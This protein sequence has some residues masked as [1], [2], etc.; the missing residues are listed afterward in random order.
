VP[1]DY[2]MHSGIL[3]LNAK[4][5]CPVEIHC[6]LV[7]VYEECVTNEENVHKRNLDPTEDSKDRVDAHIHENR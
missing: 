7:E 3:F 6:Q 2:D 5:I 4:N 1:A